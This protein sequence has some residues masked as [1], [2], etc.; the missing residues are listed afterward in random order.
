MESRIVLALVFLSAASVTHAERIEL[1][2]RSS[3]CVVDTCGGRVLSYVE[4]GAELLWTPS[5]SPGDETCWWH[6]G[7]PLAWPW[8]GRLGRGD[9]DI[10]GY[11]W[12]REFKVKS[13]SADSLVL[14]LETGSLCLSYA[15]S[16]RDALRLELHTVNRSLD[17]V[18]VAMA[19]HPYFRVGRTDQ[20][21]VLG[22]ASGPIAVT[23]A[24]DRA[25]LFDCVEFKKKLGIRDEMCKRTLR[26]VAEG[27]TGV[28]L[29]NPGPEKQCPGVIPGDA[30]RSFV[31]VE[32]FVRGVNR[33]VVLEPGSECRLAM[34][35]GCR[36]KE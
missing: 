25:V 5:D 31:A 36:F 1:H 7:I 2:G 18:P 6:G 17:P 32:P 11:A 13:R 34:T 8:F 19:F 16:V 28:N 4:D 15:I 3:T 22:M 27:A 9:A 24:V 33:F 35:I 21:F 26:I 20:S 29:W 12:K 30:W 23:G 10:H 14:D